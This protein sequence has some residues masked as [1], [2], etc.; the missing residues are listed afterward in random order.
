M[1]SNGPILPFPVHLIGKYVVHIPPIIIF[2]TSSWDTLNGHH[3][4]WYI[5][6]ILCWG[7]AC[8]ALI[9]SEG[10]K[11]LH[12]WW[13]HQM[14]TFSTL[15]AFCEGN[16]PVTVDSPHKGQWRG[17]FVFSLMCAGTNGWENNRD[18]D[19]LKCHRAH[20][21]STVML[22]E[23]RNGNFVVTGGTWGCQNGIFHFHICPHNLISLITS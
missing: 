15:L 7:D 14:E 17:A 1:F 8:L 9:T 20:P 21:D 6:D 3:I 23:T 22:I 13:R 4:A 16:P 5:D 18:A 19:D 10:Q 2:A 11:G 12:P